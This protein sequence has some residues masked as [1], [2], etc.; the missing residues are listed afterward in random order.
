[1][2]KATGRYDLIAP[3]LVSLAAAGLVFVL[4]DFTLST[5][6]L[7]VIYGLLA[8]SLDLVWG[9][10]GIFS[11]GQT[12]FF[13]VAGY[14]YGAIAIN[15]IRV[16]GE[17]ATALLGAVLMAA[18]LAALLGYFMF[19]GRV[20]D[21]YLAI[22]TLAVTLVLLSFFGSTAGS[23]YGIG[24]AQLGGYNGMVGIPPLTLGLPR[25]FAVALGVRQTYVFV[26]L[27]AG[28]IYLLLMV[29]RRAPTGR[30]LA[31]VRENELRTEL[32]GYDTRW[33][34]L[35]AFT[36]G[37][38]IAGLAG[39]AYAAWGLF[40]NP[41]VFDLPQA[42]VVVIWVLVGG[43]GTLAGAFLGTA[44]VQGLS[45]W[46]GGITS[47]TPLVLGLLLILMVLLFPNGL[48][49]L[50]GSVWRRLVERRAA[51]AALDLTV[52]A[53]E[54]PPVARTGGEACEPVLE[55]HDIAIS[56]GGLTAVDRVTTQFKQGLYSLIGPN[57]AGKSTFFNLLVGRYR[58]TTGAVVYRGRDITRLETYRRAQHGI[59][60]KLQV[61]STYVRLSVEENAWLAAYAR[62]RDARRA[63]ERAR[64]ALHEVGLLGRATDLATHLSHGEQQW[65]EIG[66]I[67][68]SD[69]QVI[70]LDEPTAGMTREET[71]RTAHLVTALARRALVLVVEHN[72]DF[73]RQLGAPVTVMHQGRIFKQGSLEEIQRDDDVLNVYLGRQVDAVR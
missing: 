56:F 40:I 9:H 49:P 11:F 5:V 60:I 41:A 15:V 46:L 4:A 66:M 73:V 3:L 6:S 33:Y 7:W 58:P 64:L 26:V 63:T 16:T 21:V 27:V 29:L 36:I 13:G 30:I 22:I 38:A 51:R 17:S 43:R 18:L 57:G 1:L 45:T 24:S 61:P 65:L 39:A 32:L 35:L 50:V 10:A 71:V 59:G 47:Q 14:T 42:V 31:A 55:T 20:S 70:L 23:Q 34:K 48:V 67:V 2:K 28:A 72:M 53:P 44:L 52:P 62:Y 68:A 37:G 8:L 69:P 25:L 19:Y 54:T 12:A